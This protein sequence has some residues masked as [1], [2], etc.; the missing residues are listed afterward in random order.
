[1]IN[2]QKIGSRIDDFTSS[3]DLKYDISEEIVEYKTNLK[4]N[5]SALLFNVVL[6]FR[7]HHLK[8]HSISIREI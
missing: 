8:N 5:K 6:I 7:N 2:Q 3:L 4:F 1:M